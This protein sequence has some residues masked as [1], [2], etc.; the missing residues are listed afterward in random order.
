[1]HGRLQTLCYGGA[2]R[3]LVRIDHAD[4]RVGAG[5]PEEEVEESE[6]QYRKDEEERHGSPVTAELLQKAASDSQHSLRFHHDSPSDSFRKASSRLSVLALA[7]SSVTVP[8]ASRGPAR[9][10][11]SRSHR[12][13]SSI[14]WLDTTMVVPPPVISLNRSQSWARSCGST[15]TVGSSSNSSS[16]RC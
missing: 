1:G 2:Q 7:G 10:R 12:A 4:G 13:A 3:P 6:D 5:A 9:I 14:T 8:S 16:G 11:P 15:P